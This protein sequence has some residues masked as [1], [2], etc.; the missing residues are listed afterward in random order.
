MKK[1]TLLPLVTLLVYMIANSDNL[2]RALQDTESSQDTEK[3]S[4]SETQE[5]DGDSKTESADEGKETQESVQS[6][7]DS[8][9]VEEEATEKHPWNEAFDWRWL[10]PTVMSGRIVD[11]AVDP[12]DDAVIFAAAASGGLWKTV[13]R[14][15]TWELSLIHI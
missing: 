12:R 14:G 15:T 1:A 6:E 8:L 10:C 4:V 13:N 7:S 5:K 2:A 11:I 3:S 9:V